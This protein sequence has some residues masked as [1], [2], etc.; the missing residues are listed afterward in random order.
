MSSTRLD[1]KADAIRDRL[2][3]RRDAAIQAAQDEL[4]AKTTLLPLRR[5]QWRKDVL[6]QFRRAVKNAADLTDEELQD[7]AKLPD[8]PKGARDRWGD[9]K[10]PME[11]FIEAKRKA[12]ERYERQSARLDALRTHEVDG[13]QYLSLTTTMLRDWFDL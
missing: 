1:Y 5:E 11:T 2:I 8:Y 7:A 4:D 9:R 12:D 13:V 6:A 10:D 3:A